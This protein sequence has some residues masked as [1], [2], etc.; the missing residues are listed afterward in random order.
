[1]H[2][3]LAFLLPPI[4]ERLRKLEPEIEIEVVADNT[5]S[6]LSRRESDIA[7]RNFR[8]VESELIAKWIRDDSARLYATEQYLESIGNPA[9]LAGYGK[10]SFISIADTA[11]IIEWLNRSGM[12]LTSRNF[13]LRT[14]S[15]LVHWSMATHRMIRLQ[16]AF[17]LDLS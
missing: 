17:E 11:L 9:G 10:A 12:T 8:P 15:Y 7:I 16:A 2:A 1:M 3:G 14:N 4:P 6:D 13:P 5:P